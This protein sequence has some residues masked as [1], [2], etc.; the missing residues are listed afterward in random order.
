VF[1]YPEVL[2]T[3]TES[4]LALFLVLVPATLMVS[5]MRFLSITTII[6]EGRRSSLSLIVIAGVIAAIAAQPQAVLLAMA[7]AYLLSGPIGLLWSRIA[8]KPAQVSELDS[9]LPS[10]GPGLR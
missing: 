4:V 3:G 7:Y 1:A 5:R 8:K 6:P 9:N 10:K 2:T